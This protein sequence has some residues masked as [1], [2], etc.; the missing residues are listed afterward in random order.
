MQKN[1][2]RLT[3]TSIVFLTLWGSGSANAGSVF[4]KNGYILQGRIV[5]RGQD[6]VVLGWQNGR[7][8]IHDRFID[9]VLLDPSEEEMIRQQKVNE[10][11]EQQ[12]SAVVFEELSLQ[13][14]EV[15]S[16]PDSYES[17]LGSGRVPEFSPQSL[18]NENN[19][20]TATNIGVSNTDPVDSDP[21]T[22]VETVPRPEIFEKI[23]AS[24]GVAIAVP[25]EWRV[26]EKENAIRVS[27]IGNP[28]RD[29]LTIDLW[30]GEG[31][32]SETALSVLEDAIAMNLPSFV[33]VSEIDRSIGGKAA[34]TL[35]CS[36]TDRG[37]ESR[38]QIVATPLGVFVLGLFLAEETPSPD[39]IG[40]ASC[41]ERV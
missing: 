27:S 15:L 10:E 33:V 3:L 36:D 34:K 7:V 18:D 30:P 20:S 32:D 26:D 12:R 13:G 23:F 37:V 28:T 2:K 4:L 29:Y 21:A 35:A 25:E 22:V 17:I 11:V 39:Q 31:I 5:E 41:R 6:M 1:Y 38:Q 24:I 9:E 14:N 40:R 19:V 16:L 8:T